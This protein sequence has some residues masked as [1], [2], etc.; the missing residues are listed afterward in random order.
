MAVIPARGG[1]KRL[2]YKNIRRFF[3]HP[4]LA[5]AIAAAQNSRLFSRVVVSSDDPLVG[6][7]ATWYGAEFLL[8]P[9]ELASDT[10]SL[11]GVA[12]HVLDTLAAGSAR[13]E[14]L[15]QLM[16]NCPLRRSQD[17]VRLYDLFRHGERAFQISVVRYRGTYP[18]WALVEDESGHGRLYFGEQYRIRSQELKHAFC[19]TG[20]IWWTRIAAFRRQCC[21]YGPPFHLVEMDADRG[22]DI[23]DAEELAL[24]EV[25]ARGLEARDGRS[26]LEPV[27]RSPFPGRVPDD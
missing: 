14:T 26:P 3:G 5:Y 17:I 24:A 9:A 4:M 6:D 21:F 13:P 11:E 15:C 25:I 1:S 27:S 12:L 22:L 16:P 2:P 20:A 7:I 23:D 10:A 18:H 8:R 19:A